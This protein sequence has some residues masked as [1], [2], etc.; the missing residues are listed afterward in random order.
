M[1]S[2]GV[3]LPV[4]GAGAAAALRAARQRQGRLAGAPGGAVQRCSCPL[5]DVRGASLRDVS[6]TPL[7]DV[8]G[9]LLRDGDRA[10]WPVTAR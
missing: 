2:R 6:G 10:G 9:T 4:R 3:C 8:S 7:R 1:T 5:R